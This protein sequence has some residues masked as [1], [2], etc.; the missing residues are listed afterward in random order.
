MCAASSFFTQLSTQ[1]VVCQQLSEK[2]TLLTDGIPMAALP[3]PPLDST[4][5]RDATITVS[6][7]ITCRKWGRCHLIPYRFDRSRARFVRGGQGQS[8][9]RLFRVLCVARL[10]DQDRGAWGLPQV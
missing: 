5:C 2:R 4:P 6:Q 10:R 9:K 3:P 1:Q 7:F 8:T